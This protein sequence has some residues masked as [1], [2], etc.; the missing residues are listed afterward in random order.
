MI[1]IPDSYNTKDWT[2]VVLEK[3]TTEDQYN[4]LQSQ[5]GGMFHIHRAGTAIKF[6][7]KEDAEWFLL[8]LQQ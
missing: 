5:Q 1:Y 4:L 7:R 2:N 3:P 6:E 8:R